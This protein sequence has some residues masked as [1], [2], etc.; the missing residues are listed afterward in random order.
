MRVF[1][2]KKQNV[3][4]GL[5]SEDF[6]KTGT[7]ERRKFRRLDLKGWQY[8]NAREWKGVR[9]REICPKVHARGV[10]AYWEVIDVAWSYPRKIVELESNFEDVWSRKEFQIRV[11]GASVS[12]VRHSNLSKDTC[13]NRRDVRKLFW[14]PRLHIWF[15]GRKSWKKLVGAFGWRRVGT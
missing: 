4:S 5:V 15:G 13:C 2:N 8:W 6:A 12:L 11:C 10:V 14:M 9:T 7:K 1:Q 3:F